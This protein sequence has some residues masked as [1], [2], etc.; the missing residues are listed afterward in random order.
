[1][2]NFIAKGH[3]P[4][5][6]SEFRVH[7]ADDIEE[8]TVIVFLNGA[9]GDELRDDGTVAVDLVLEVRVKVL[10]VRVVGHDYQ[11]DEVGVLDQTV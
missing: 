6:T 2:R 4:E 8:D 10:V 3:A 5:V 7:L 9:I 11:E 1:M